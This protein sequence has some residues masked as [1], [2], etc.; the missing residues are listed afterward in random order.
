ML[1]RSTPTHQEDLRSMEP[2][3]YE[4]D[5]QAVQPGR[6]RVG[7]GIPRESCSS[8]TVGVRGPDV[9]RTSIRADIGEAV[10]FPV[11]SRLGRVRDQEMLIGPVLIHLPEVAAG[12]RRP[13][14]E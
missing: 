7:S 4:S 2:V 10:A 3:A 6:T 8:P 13:G 14:E 1:M 11:P 5:P 9:R 12:S